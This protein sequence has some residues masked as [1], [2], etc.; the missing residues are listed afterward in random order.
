MSLQKV[1]RF[2]LKQ[3]FPNLN[4]P[5]EKLQRKLLISDGSSARFQANRS[6]A[7]AA[8]SGGIHQFDQPFNQ[9]CCVEAGAGRGAVGRGGNVNFSPLIIGLTGLV[10]CDGITITP[11]AFLY[12]LGSL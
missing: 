3:N 8:A 7:P 1:A 6:A 10:F 4:F 2:F 9:P 12:L 11:S 5:N